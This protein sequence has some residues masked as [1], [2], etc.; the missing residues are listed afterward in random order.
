ME[1]LQ[2]S[3]TNTETWLWTQSLAEWSSIYENLSALVYFI[4]QRKEIEIE[5]EKFIYQNKHKIV[6]D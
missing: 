6:S 1:Q 2:I 3:I 5:I 4:Q